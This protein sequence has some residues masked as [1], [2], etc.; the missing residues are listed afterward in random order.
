MK[1]EKLGPETVKY[2]AEIART[3][4][5][6]KSLA[7]IVFA[8]MDISDDVATELRDQLSAELERQD[9]I[10]HIEQ[11][12]SRGTPEQKDNVI[13]ELMLFIHVDEDGKID[14]EKEV[15]GADFVD[16]VISLLNE[17]KF[18]PGTGE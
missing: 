14:P 8:K 7:N 18:H 17:N 11:I 9:V 4:M 12:I 6:D 1:L 16:F 13:R 2:I 3:V 5:A 10:Q 15:P